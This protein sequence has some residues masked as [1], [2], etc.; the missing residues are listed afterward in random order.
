MAPL[1]PIA[2]GPEFVRRLTRSAALAALLI[3]VSLGIGVVGYHWFARLAWIDAFLNAS[4]ILAGMGPVDPL[5]TPGSKLFAGTYALFSGVAF[6]S[7]VGLLMAPV[8]HRFL[9][10][11]HID[12]AS[13]GDEPEGS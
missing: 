5:P 7:I 4:M 11:F 9:H 6:L 1:K 8:L 12:L 3:A 10:R 13:D 2:P